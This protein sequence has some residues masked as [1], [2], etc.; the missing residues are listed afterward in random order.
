MG[1][2]MKYSLLFVGCLLALVSTVVAAEQTLLLRQPDVSAD[3]L[4]FV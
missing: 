3:K 4:A 2:S 1:L